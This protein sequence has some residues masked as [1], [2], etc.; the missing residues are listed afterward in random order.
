MDGLPV[1]GPVDGVSGLHVA[2]GH[3]MLGLTLGPV[4]GEMM[5]NAILAGGDPRLEGL[6]PGRFLRR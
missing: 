4:T 2:T 3:G 5:A 1:V 6:G